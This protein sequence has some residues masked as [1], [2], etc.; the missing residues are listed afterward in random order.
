ME[1]SYVGRHLSCPHYKK[2]E[3]PQATILKYN[4]GD[5]IERISPQLSKLCFIKYGSINIS[6][7]GSEKKEVKGKE[8]FLLP[9]N[10]E[11]YAEVIEDVYI[12]TFQ[13]QIQISLC[14][15]YS[16]AQ[17]FPYYKERVEQELFTLKFTPVI[18]KYLDLLDLYLTDGIHCMSFYELKKQ[19]LF[20]L[21]R[22]YYPKE[23]L[24]V[25]FHPILSEEDIFFKN[26]VIEKS[27]HVKNVSELAK[28]ANYST[29]GFIKKFTR[30]FNEAPHRWMTQYKAEHILHA[31]KNE[32]KSLKEICLE[33]NFSS[34]SHFV[35][36]CKKQFGETPGKMRKENVL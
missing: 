16:M 30:C 19:E 8:I 13:F 22:A 34:M 21:L 11:F 6:I 29:S 26:F 14:E 2:E 36:F 1:L 4:K 12:I 10:S 5:A 28:M 31:I 32:D 23:D 35:N 18:S 9:P 20:T 33:Y 7:G 17:L 15:S 3:Y 25:F 27:L 24:A